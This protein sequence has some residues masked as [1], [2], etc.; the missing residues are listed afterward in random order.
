MEQT[1]L[2]KYA[3]LVVG[4][5]LNLQNGQILV[6]SAPV[7]CYEF[8]HMVA[9]SA[10]KA[11]C[12]NVVMDWEDAA[13]THML[14]TEAAEET[15]N[16]FPEWKKSY[17]HEYLQR[18]AAFLKIVASDPAVMA[19]VP[20]QRM[21]QYYKTV[22]SNMGEYQ[23]RLGT[24][25]N[26][27]NVVAL[28]TASW[29]KHVFPQMSEGDAIEALWKGICRS[30]RLNE[31]D[32]VDAWEKH[33]SHLD[34]LCE[35]LNALRLVRLQYKNGLGTDFTVSL[36]AGHKWVSGGEKLPDGTAFLPNMPTE[37]IFTV[38][39]KSS[40]AGTIVGAMPLV[41]KNGGVVE[42]FILA[43][44]NGKVVRYHAEKGLD[45]LEELLH[46]DEGSCY[47]GE[48]ALVS[49]DCPVA[50][51]GIL[52]FNTLFD[53]NAA[54]HLALGNGLP[55]CLQE[56]MTPEHAEMNT[57]CVHQDFMIGTKDLSVIGYTADGREI[58]LMDNGCFSI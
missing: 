5:G 19:D 47:L 14:L 13:L 38:P 24:S 27:W 20:P 45:V 25:Q 32:P 6:I 56:G 42:N 55:F 11:G 58:T 44:E 15:L 31:D 21:G 2:K 43:L 40:A 39:V 3:D 51:T 7:E 9:K 29:A 12:S 35:K 33:L 41:T 1:T 17:Y 54:C 8:V 10:W 28:P 57:S 34:T 22:A 48:V 53:E 26:A 52:Y 18:G 16:E 37:E 46:T 30:V 50:A 49:C 36:P 4:T 23:M